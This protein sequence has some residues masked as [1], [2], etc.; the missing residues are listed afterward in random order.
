MFYYIITTT[1]HWRHFQQN[2]VILTSYLCSNFV[3]FL[4]YF[5][6][7]ELMQKTTCEYLYFKFSLYYNNNP[8]LTSFP[9]K[10]RHFDVIFMSDDSNFV[11][12]LFYFLISELMQKTACEYLYF[13]FSLY[14]NNNPTLTSFPTKWRHFDVVFMS[15]DSNFV[16]FLFYFLISELMQKNRMLI[17]LF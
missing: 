5:L 9:T 14:Y 12:F 15:D 7:S 17:S 4:F 10:L 6:I 11:T 3:T 16:T 2:N 8:T 13:K 1:R